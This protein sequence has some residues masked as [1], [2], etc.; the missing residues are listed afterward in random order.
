[1]YRKLNESIVV[2]DNFGFEIEVNI[3]RWN[4]RYREHG[5]SLK[6]NI[7]PMSDPLGIAV[8]SDTIDQWESPH[9]EKISAVEK[10]QILNNIRGGLEVLDCPY[11]VF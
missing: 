1:M 8:Y 11:Q 10:E 2:S 9:K 5:K 3:N 6:I 7:E 4:I